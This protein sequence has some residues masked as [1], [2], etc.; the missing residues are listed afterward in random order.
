[1]QELFHVVKPLYKIISHK[2]WLCAMSGDFQSDQPQCSTH[3]LRI[4]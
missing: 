1:M 3:A 4:Y 2:L